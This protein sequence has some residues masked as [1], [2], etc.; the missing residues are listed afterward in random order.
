ML[1]FEQA[2]AART[3]NIGR[4]DI[5]RPFSILETQSESQ[6]AVGQGTAGRTRLSRIRSRA[7]SWIEQDLRIQS[8]VLR[9]VEDIVR[10]NQNAETAVLARTDGNKLRHGHVEIADVGVS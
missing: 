3:E 10:L 6:N 9:L 7:G 5:P 8:I 2:E 1:K 4:R